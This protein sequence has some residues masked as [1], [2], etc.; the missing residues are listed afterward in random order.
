MS[1]VILYDA[2]PLLTTIG[3]RT[4]VVGIDGISQLVVQIEDTLNARNGTATFDLMLGMTPTT[5]V[6]H[7]T[8]IVIGASDTVAIEPE[9]LSGFRYATLACTVAGTGGECRVTMVGVRKRY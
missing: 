4:P 2:V 3:A 6:S 1:R 5:L 9:D 7:P 8:P